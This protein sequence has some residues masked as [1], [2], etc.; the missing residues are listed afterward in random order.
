MLPLTCPVSG[1]VVEILY[2]LTFYNNYFEF[3][4]SFAGGYWKWHLNDNAHL[5]PHLV[6]YCSAGRSTKARDSESLWSGAVRS[7][8]HGIMTSWQQEP[9]NQVRILRCYKVAANVFW[10]R[11]LHSLF[12]ESRRRTRLYCCVCVCVCVTRTV[13]RQRLSKHNQ[14]KVK[15]TLRPTICR[16]VRLGVRRPSGTRNQFFFLLM[17]FS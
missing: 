14:V 16:P 15:V 11:I 17:I 6:R 2:R 7:W 1:N 10:P 9:Q 13:T 4:I 5:C 3:L 12:W 8:S